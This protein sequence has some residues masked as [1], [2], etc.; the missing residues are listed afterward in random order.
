MLT[1][2]TGP[3]WVA[4]WRG[5]RDPLSAPSASSPGGVVWFIGQGG[6]G[7]RRLAAA[8]VE[9]ADSMENVIENHGAVVNRRGWTDGRATPYPL[10]RTGHPQNP[11]LHPSGCWTE[12]L[13]ATG[14]R[15]WPEGP[16]IYGHVRN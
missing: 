16:E 8:V 1:K 12:G 15:R 11:P 7:P 9:P 6:A 5:V 4:V 2:A 14:I 3:Q 10:W 13:L